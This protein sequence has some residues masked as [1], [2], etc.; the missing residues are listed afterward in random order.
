MISSSENRQTTAAVFRWLSVGI[1]ALSVVSVTGAVIFRIV[2]GLDRESDAYLGFAT[3]GALLA[4]L[5]GGVSGVYSWFIARSGVT[6]LAVVS[7]F[8]SFML[9]LLLS[10]LL[11][12]HW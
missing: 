5:V 9:A 1:A 10:M 8:A 3:A 7:C 2:H 4:L 11:G 6:A 12:G